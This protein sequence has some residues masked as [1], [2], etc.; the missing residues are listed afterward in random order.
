[1]DM[2]ML[3]MILRFFDKLFETLDRQDAA[4]IRRQERKILPKQLAQKKKK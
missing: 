3:D 1:M 4:K 2:D